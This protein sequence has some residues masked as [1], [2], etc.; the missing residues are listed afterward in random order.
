MDINILDPK[1]APFITLRLVSQDRISRAIKSE[2]V[3]FNAFLDKGIFVIS[4]GKTQVKF[5]KNRT[6]K[7]EKPISDWS[8]EVNKYLNRGF[9]FVTT[10]QVQKRK[11]KVTNGFKAIADKVLSKFIESIVVANDEKL[12]QEYSKSIEEIPAECIE[13]ANKILINMQK[14]LED[15]SLTAQSF[16]TY[17]KELFVQLPIAISKQDGY[18]ATSSNKKH[19]EDTISTLQDKLDSICQQLRTFNEEEER[20]KKGD[21]CLET[22]LEANN[23]E[24]RN[25][26][27]DEKKKILECM[28]DQSDNYVRAWHVTNHATEKR[29]QDY[30]KQ[31]GLTEENGISHLW[32]GTGF[33]NLWSIFKS[34]LYLNPEAIKSNVRICGKAFG[35]GLYFAPYCKKSMGYTSAAG[36]MHRGDSSNKGG[37]IL[38]FKVATGKPYDIYK[39]GHKRPNHWE[40]FHRDHPDR[41]CTWAGGDLPGAN[42]LKRLA[43]DEVIVYQECQATIEY[44][45]EFSDITR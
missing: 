43:Y 30:C 40:D 44:V 31:E 32:H 15:D 13:Q 6:M 36:A 37:Y 5:G 19:F 23:L 41:H 42:G 18:F 9:Q 10:K 8:S 34:G 25:V 2:T 1:E 26:T 11:F 33:E 16:N 24:M 28:S 7:T 17:L 12:K 45:V 39:E 3:E 4:S 35:Y 20:A 29:F 21:S 22:I 27:E 38:I 14:D